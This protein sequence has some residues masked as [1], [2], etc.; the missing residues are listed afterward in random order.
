MGI[1]PPPPPPKALHR[2]LR[3]ISEILVEMPPSATDSE[4][5]AV[6]GRLWPLVDTV[7]SYTTT[8][9]RADVNEVRDETLSAIK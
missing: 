8:K 1:M 9:R 5:Y 6:C 4:L 7:S 3:Q 2:T